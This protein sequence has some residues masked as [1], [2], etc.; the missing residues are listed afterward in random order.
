MAE[1]NTSIQKIESI[2]EQIRQ[3]QNRKKQLLQQ[4]KEAER[5]ARTK[6]LIERGAILESLLDRAATLTN[7]QVQTILTAALNSEPALE[8]LLAAQERA[9]VQPGAG[10]NPA[11][12]LPARR[13]PLWRLPRRHG[14][15]AG[16]APSL[17]GKGALIHPNGCVR[18]AGG[19][20]H[21]PLQNW[22]SAFPKP[23][24]YKAASHIL[25]DTACRLVLF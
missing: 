12:I 7:T 11:R 9:A 1:N 3:L 19:V 2:E 21:L 5:K 14:F 8:A 15:G 24:A 20:L 6:R 22:E 16:V 18:P 23:H 13:G 25:W 10:G 4:Q 17:A